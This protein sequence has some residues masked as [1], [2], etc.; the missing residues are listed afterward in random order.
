MKKFL[1][2]LT[3]IGRAQAITGKHIDDMGWEDIIVLF[4]DEGWVDLFNDVVE[5]F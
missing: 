4:A 2:L 5:M 1:L 3:L